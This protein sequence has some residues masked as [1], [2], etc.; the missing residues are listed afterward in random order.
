VSTPASPISIRIAVDHPALPGHFPGRPIAPAAL[1]LDEVIYALRPQRDSDAAPG[2][3][4]RR[5]AGWRLDVVKFHR[6]VPPELAL[7]LLWQC[8]P[9]GR[10]SFELCAGA[11]R[12][13]SGTL[14]AV[15]DA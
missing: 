3:A 12:Y 1:L 6:P 5:A 8:E 11:E 14:A 4:S 9:R 2:A 10:V 13:V 7:Q 15:G